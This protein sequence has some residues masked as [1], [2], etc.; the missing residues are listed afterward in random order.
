MFALVLLN[1]TRNVFVLLCEQKHIN[2]LLKL[3]ERYTESEK[4][5]SHLRMLRI[6]HN[7]IIMIVL[8]KC[9]FGRK[10]LLPQL[11]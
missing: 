8:K 2:C 11:A 4:Q 5:S 3:Q 6:L 10:E 9:I 1:Y 7:Y